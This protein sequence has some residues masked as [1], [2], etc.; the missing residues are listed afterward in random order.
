MNFIK[1]F[2][3]VGILFTIIILAAIPISSFLYWQPITFLE[4]P[5]FLRITAMMWIAAIP[6]AWS[7]KP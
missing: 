7:M 1:Y 4:W 6:V 5:V 2:V 3:C